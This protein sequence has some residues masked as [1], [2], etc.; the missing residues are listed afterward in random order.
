MRERKKGDEKEE[1]RIPD[2]PVCDDEMCEM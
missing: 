2:P 1:N